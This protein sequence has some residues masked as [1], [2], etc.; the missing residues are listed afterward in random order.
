M[1]CNYAIDCKGYQNDINTFTKSACEIHCLHEE[2]KWINADIDSI[3]QVHQEFRENN[4][5]IKNLCLYTIKFKDT[6]KT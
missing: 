6:P 3:E 4:P 2:N 5:L 1:R